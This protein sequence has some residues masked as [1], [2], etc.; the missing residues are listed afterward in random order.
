MH[1]YLHNCTPPP[2]FTT[3]PPLPSQLYPP[4]L[5]NCTPPTFTTVP[6]PTFTTVPHHLHNYLYPP[7]P[8][9]YMRPLKELSLGP[10]PILSKQQVATLFGPIEQILSAQELFYSALTSRTLAW[11]TEQKIGD[12]FL[13][14]ISV[15]LLSYQCFVFPVTI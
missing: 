3:V 4:Y 15:T 8:Q 1:P 2:T 11:N 10:S 6:P 7:P 5:H 12:V 9:V 14:S 13:S